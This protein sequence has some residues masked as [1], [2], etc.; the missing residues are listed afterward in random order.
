MQGWSWHGVRRV[1]GEVV[2]IGLAA[3]VVVLAL[4]CSGEPTAMPAV[5]ATVAGAAAAGDQGVEVA[6]AAVAGAA[7]AGGQGVEVAAATVPAAAGVAAPGAVAVGQGATVPAATVAATVTRAEGGQGAVASARAGTAMPKLPPLT[8]VLI[9]RQG[10]RLMAALS[11]GPGG[12]PGI[13]RRTGMPRGPVRLGSPGRPGRTRG[14]VVAGRLT[15]AG[16]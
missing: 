6:A 15:W 1:G 5:P 4:A 7:A 9:Y 3:G 2:R 11:R 10:V 16:S 8:L 12:R 14:M 13:L